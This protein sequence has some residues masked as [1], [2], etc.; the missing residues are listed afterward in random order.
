MS[1]IR[2]S[3]ARWIN[4]RLDKIESTSAK[5]AKHFVP[6]EQIAKRQRDAWQRLHRYALDMS[7]DWD[8]E[9]ARLWYAEWERSLGGIGC[10]CRAHWRK[11]IAEMPPRFESADA[12]FH[13]SVDGHNRVNESLGKPI[14][15]YADAL[16]RWTESES[17]TDIV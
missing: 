11:I 9:I 13:W 14:I 12:F 4:H 16:S 10:Q 17:D 5:Q 8:Y 2:Q 7:H 6:S 3:Y 1:V 15:G